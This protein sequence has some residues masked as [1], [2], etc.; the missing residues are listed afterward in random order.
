M[1]LTFR[2]IAIRSLSEAKKPMAV[3]EIWDFAQ[4]TFPSQIKTSGKTPVNSLAVAIYDDLKKSESSPFVFAGERPR[5]FGLKEWEEAKSEAGVSVSGV[6]RNLEDLSE[7]GLYPLVS[8]FLENGLLIDQHTLAKRIQHARSK[9][10]GEGQNRWLHPDVVALSIPKWSQA[11]MDL[12]V[13]LDLF[14][15]FTSVEVK[16]ALTSSTIHESFFQAVSNSS[17][18]NRGY[19]IAREIEDK[20]EFL[21]R[22]RRLSRMYG[23][24]VVKL[25]IENPEES[26][27]LFP[28]A[29]RKEVDVEFVD[30]LASINPDFQS[31]LQA[32]MDAIKTQR[33]NPSFF[34]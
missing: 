31:V 23:I 22:L 25:D 15:V 20:P 19:L 5:R 6:A 21:R 11:A 33:L 1:G 3:D 14:V 27:T 26:E 16:L 13:N 4:K 30:H 28:S 17:W 32:A 34:K 7:E 12:A 24:G 8:R 18:A 2:E 29:H 10:K 9:N